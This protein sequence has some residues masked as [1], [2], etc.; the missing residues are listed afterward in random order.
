MC[1]G[2]ISADVALI[3]RASRCKPGRPP[4]LLR[5]LDRGHP[6]AVGG[7]STRFG[8]EKLPEALGAFR[9][10]RS[11]VEG[12]KAI[13]G[14]R[15]GGSASSRR[16]VERWRR[17]ALFANEAMRARGPEL[18][19]SFA[20]G[21]RKRSWRRFTIGVAGPSVVARRTV[22]GGAHNPP[23]ARRLAVIIAARRGALASRLLP[24]WLFLSNLAPLPTSCPRASKFPPPSPS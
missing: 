3:P 7:S 1:P 24:A 20:G 13:R 21:G 8:N 19:E 22:P 17:K 2:P 23:P 14:R 11:A 5:R 12:G 18:F 10:A 6:V 15:P 4:I 16:P 9:R